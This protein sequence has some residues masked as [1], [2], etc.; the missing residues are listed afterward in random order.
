MDF[1]NIYG[2]NAAIDNLIGDFIREQKKLWKKC[3]KSH[4]LLSSPSSLTF[5]LLQYFYC[6][7]FKPAESTGINDEESRLLWPSS[8]TKASFAP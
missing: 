6:I 7:E 5:F 4:S 1:A 8:M 3:V 2:L